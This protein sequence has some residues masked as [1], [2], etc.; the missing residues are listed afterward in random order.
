MARMRVSLRRATHSEKELILT[1][2]ELVVDITQRR[3]SVGGRE[4]KLTPTEYTILKELMQNAGKV[5]THKQLLVKI[6]GKYHTEDTHYVRI[7]ISQLR[8]KIEEKPAQP[9]YIIS[10][11]GIG[12]RLMCK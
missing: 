9:R 7:F 4:V 2:G 12:Y 3:V 6:W 1:C 10:E 8:H 11:P 5:I